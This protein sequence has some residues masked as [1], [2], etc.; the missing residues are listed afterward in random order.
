MSE[1]QTLL[2]DALSGAGR[3]A[4]L[5]CGSPV[6]GD[7]QAGL[8]VAESLAHLTGRAR[9][10]WGSSAPE[11]FTGEIKR[12]QP[13]VLLVVD[14][15]D[16]GRPPGTVALIP[17]DEVGGVSFSTHMLPLKIILDY[18]RRETGCGTHLLGVQPSALEF[19]EELS[20]EV[21]GAVAEIAEALES[22]LSAE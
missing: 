10:F 11:N 4:I 9:A 19:G 8:K 22:C 2:A 5:G 13:D 6:R 14:A 15:A 21:S 7:D 12:F 16:M 1:W 3:V 17:A 18:L 20:P